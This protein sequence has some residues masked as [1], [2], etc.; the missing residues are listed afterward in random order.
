MVTYST[1]ALQLGC[2]YLYEIRCDSVQWILS[3]YPKMNRGLFYKITSYRLER[4]T[5]Q[6]FDEGPVSH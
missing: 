1:L 5:I 2:Y 6:S 4:C 3:L